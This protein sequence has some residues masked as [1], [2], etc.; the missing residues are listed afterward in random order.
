MQKLKNN[1]SEIRKGSSN[2][3]VISLTTTP[4][5]FVQN[6]VPD[7]GPHDGIVLRPILMHNMPAPK[8]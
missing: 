2:E 1:K 3:I 8:A 4:S 6:C 7:I 5:N